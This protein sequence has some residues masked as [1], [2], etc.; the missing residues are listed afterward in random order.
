M[1]YRMQKEITSMLTNGIV[2]TIG[3]DVHSQ[4]YSIY[5]ALWTAKKKDVEERLRIFEKAEKKIAFP[6]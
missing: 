2:R 6:V 5:S 1:P 3:I 4:T